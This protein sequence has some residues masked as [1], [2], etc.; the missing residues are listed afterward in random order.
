MIKYD[1]Y[2]EILY[3]NIEESFKNNIIPILIKNPEFINIFLTNIEK[4]ILIFLR[5]YNEPV[6]IWKL[7]LFINKYYSRS[8]ISVTLKKL[9]CFKMVLYYDGKFRDEKLWFITDF[10]FKNIKTIKYDRKTNSF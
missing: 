4:N 8:I 2:Q 1:N 3:N 9:K 10:G 7:H 5:Y 6:S